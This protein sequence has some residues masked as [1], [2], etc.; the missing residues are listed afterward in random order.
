MPFIEAA[1]RIE[2]LQSAIQPRECSWKCVELG[3]AMN[4]RF[5]RECGPYLG[6]VDVRECA[7][8]VLEFAG[9]VRARR[10]SDFAVES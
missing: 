3:D 7:G 10:Q 5:G 4:W 2:I 1:E 9:S 8:R 6:V